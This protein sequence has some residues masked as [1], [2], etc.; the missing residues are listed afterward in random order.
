MTNE[1]RNVDSQWKTSQQFN[2]DD[3]DVD[4]GQDYTTLSW[5]NRSIALVSAIIED[6]EHVVTGVRFRRSHNHI[7]LEVR[8]TRFDF[9]T[10]HLKDPGKSIWIG[11]NAIL[12]EVKIHR[13]DVPTKSRVKSTFYPENNNFVR[14]QPTDFEKDASQTTIPFLDASRL[15]ASSPLAGVGL[16]YKSTYGYGGFIGPKLIVFDFGKYIT[17]PSYI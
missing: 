5:A 10:G 6:N 15:E 11:N 8:A 4:E 12:R 9:E 13:P 17:P 7:R 1:P 16:Y 2:V 3:E 14:F